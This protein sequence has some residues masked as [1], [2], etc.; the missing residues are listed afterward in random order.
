MT[1]HPARRPGLCALLLATLAT[2]AQAGTTIDLAADASRP[3][4][5]DLVRVTLFSEASGPSPAEVARKVNGEINEA[6]KWIKTVPAV[7]GKTGNSSSYPI[8]GKG[9]G[10]ESWRLHS[11]ILLESQDPAAVSEL[12]GKLQNRLALGGITLLPSDSTR[13]QAEDAATRDAIGAF[14]SRARVIAEALGKTYRLKHL[15]VSQSGQ[16]MPMPMLRSA[17]AM[18]AEAAPLPIEAGESQVSVS[19][20]G[21]IELAD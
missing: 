4:A 15:S 5:N 9:R 6:L 8:Y 20:S 7:T 18:A 17:K 16:V 19:V 2:G 13:R 1:V 10:I 12:V 21:Q 11:E 14:H 3:A